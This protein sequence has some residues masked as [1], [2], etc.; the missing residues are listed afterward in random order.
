LH[1]FPENCLLIFAFF[2]FCIPFYVESE[3]KSGTGSGTK[4]GNQYGSGSAQA[5]SGGSG[6]G[7]TT[8]SK[9]YNNSVKL[10]L[11]DFLPSSPLHSMKE[12]LAMAYTDCFFSDWLFSK[13]QAVFNKRFQ[14]QTRPFRLSG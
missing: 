7:S 1:C 9:T 3:S 12:K 2:D 10:S 11:A 13:S 6:S 14:G 5:K 8:L 4:T